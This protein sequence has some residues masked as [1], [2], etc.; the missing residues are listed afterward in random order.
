[1]RLS[2]PEAPAITQIE[3]VDADT[4]PALSDAADAKIMA[5]R[6]VI[7]RN[8][9]TRLVRLANAEPA[10]VSNFANQGHR[11]HWDLLRRTGFDPLAR[12]QTL[13]DGPYGVRRVGDEVWYVWP[14]LA[15]LDPE[16]LQPERLSFRDRA[17]LR[18][19]VGDE[20][21]ARIRNGQGYPGVRT[22]IA[23]DGRWLYFVHES[24]DEAETE[25]EE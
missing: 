14:D 2:V 12:L 25:R 7:A 15:A 17:R 1:M 13:L 11:T 16:E 8:S 20:G 10:F 6:E 19:F 4:R 5:L 3:P 18:D 24:E 22:A 23:E 21:L 9:L